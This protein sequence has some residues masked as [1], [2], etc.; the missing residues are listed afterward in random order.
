MLYVAAGIMVIVLVVMG[1][2]MLMR[3]G[4]DRKLKLKAERRD[5]LRYLGQ[6]RKQ[7]RRSV[8]RQRESALFT[9]P[10]PARLWALV[11]TDR[12]W[13]RRAAH[14]DFAEVRIGLGQQRLA[15]Q[16]QA[17]QTKPVA[18]LEPLCA[19]ALRRF[20]RAY[21]LIEDMPV[22]VY[23]RGFARISLDGEL[24]VTRAMA[25]AILAQLATLHSS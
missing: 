23:L 15:L 6:V 5:Y 14:A 2:A 24:A 3:A 4:T 9:H 22:A 7:V 21:T 18:D 25:R 19:S 11:P 13:E 20:L 17:P 10:D 16:M 12:L 1:G 8:D